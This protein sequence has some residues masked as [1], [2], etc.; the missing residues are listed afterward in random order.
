MHVN[1]L[2][3][4]YLHDLDFGYNPHVHIT[5]Q[6]GTVLETSF[7]TRPCEMIDSHYRICRIED[8]QQTENYW[9]KDLSFQYY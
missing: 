1:F 4:S 6:Y 9:L 7:H 8:M 3:M 5:E 2:F